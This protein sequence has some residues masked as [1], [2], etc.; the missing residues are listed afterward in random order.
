MR[1][2][3]ALS[4]ADGIPFDQAV[5]DLRSALKRELVHLL[6]PL[7]VCSML[8]L[9]NA[10]A[11]K[12]NFKKAT[13]SL[14]FR[15][16]HRE[17]AKRLGVSVATIRQARLRPDASAH[18]TAPENWREAVVRIAEAQIMRY[19]KLIDEMRQESADSQ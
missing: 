3:H 14:F 6:N 17:L 18:R 7:L 5:D 2:G 12:M 16:G 1:V 8:R 19:R 15:I 13:D 9:V 4:R 10:S 11:Y